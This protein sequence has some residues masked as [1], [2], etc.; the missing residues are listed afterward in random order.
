MN[1]E[2]MLL[3]TPEKQERKVD[4]I[5]AIDLPTPYGEAMLL[6]NMA[7]IDSDN[8]HVRHVFKAPG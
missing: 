8:G 2:R 3:D 4:F 7:D 5:F 1:S 6:K